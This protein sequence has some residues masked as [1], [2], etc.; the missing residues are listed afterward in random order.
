MKSP[1]IKEGIENTFNATN[2]HGMLEHC[3]AVT[4]LLHHELGVSLSTCD[5]HIHP[6]PHGLRGR[7]NH[8]VDSVV[9]LYTEGQ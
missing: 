5:D 1:R 7:S 8:V 3:A 6:D 2:S 4:P 9:S